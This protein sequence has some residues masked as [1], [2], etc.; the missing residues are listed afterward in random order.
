MT[1]FLLFVI[2]ALVAN[3]IT[4][5]QQESK[6]KTESKFQKKQIE[7]LEAER[8]TLREALAESQRAREVLLEERTQERIQLARLEEQ[9]RQHS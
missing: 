1:Y 4:L 7:E 3:L 6:L 8:A 2:V 5:F 9:I